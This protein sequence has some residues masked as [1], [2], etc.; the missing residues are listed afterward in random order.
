M[1]FVLSIKTLRV[2]VKTISVSPQSLN[3]RPGKHLSMLQLQS[4]A[5]QLL[6]PNSTILHLLQSMLR[7]LL[8]LLLLLLRSIFQIFVHLIML[9]C[10][11]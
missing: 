5:P 1:H 2:Y 9:S 8:L 10:H 4:V 11:I 7:F 3:I 6:K